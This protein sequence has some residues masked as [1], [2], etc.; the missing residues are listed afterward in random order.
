MVCLWE[1]DIVI[2]FKAFNNFEDYEIKD[3]RQG[4]LPVCAKI[5]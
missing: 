1:F 4:P 2:M 3:T 5:K